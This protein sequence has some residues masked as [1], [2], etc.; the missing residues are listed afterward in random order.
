MFQTLYIGRAY[1][2]AF[3]QLKTGGVSCQATACIEE[4]LLDPADVIGALGLA[5][6]GG[7]HKAYE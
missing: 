4:F 6:H 5:V 1:A 2:A 7:E 3:R